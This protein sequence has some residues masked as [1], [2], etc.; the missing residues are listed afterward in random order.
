MPHKINKA[1]VTEAF[2]RFR[3]LMPNALPR[4]I[5]EAGTPT[6][7]IVENTG[8]A[9]D[10]LALLSHAQAHAALTAWLDGYAHGL[11]VAQRR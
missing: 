7:Y 4:L 1:D 10:G 8:T 3:A 11:A 5:V 9:L 6:L 2:D